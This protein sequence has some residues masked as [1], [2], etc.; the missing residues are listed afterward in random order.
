MGCCS[1][2]YLDENDKKE[3]KVTGCSYFCK[4]KNCYVTG[5][6]TIC[7]N[8]NIDYSRKKYISDELYHN[9]V[10]FYADFDLD[11]KDSWLG[12]FD[13]RDYINDELMKIVL[14]KVS[15]V[16]DY[17]TFYLLNSEEKLNHINN[18]VV[19][20]ITNHYPN[21][22][23]EDYIQGKWKFFKYTLEIEEAIKSIS[24]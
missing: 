1:C 17:V 8:F 21:I 2:K 7:D 4:K 22:K 5:N 19:K 15:E 16:T 23:V 12:F 24:K 11:K 3:G 10:E 13:K 18:S 20:E 9:G 6:S 14:K